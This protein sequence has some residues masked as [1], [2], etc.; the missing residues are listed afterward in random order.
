ML[1][2]R[3]HLDT[4]YDMILDQRAEEGVWGGSGGEPLAAVAIATIVIAIV[5]KVAL[6][7]VVVIAVVIALVV[8]VVVVVVVVM[9]P[10]NNGSDSVR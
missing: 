1:E 4:T 5:I 3:H 8:I 9:V 10:S 2:A 7:V 6:T